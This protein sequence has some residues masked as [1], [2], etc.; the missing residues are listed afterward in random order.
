MI[1]RINAK[2]ETALREALG[3]V[4]RLQDE[5]QIE[6]ALAVLDDEERT[7]AIGLAIVI[8]GY[9]AVDV[10]GTRWLNQASFRQF[11]EDLATT[12]KIAERYQL[13]TE[14]VYQYLSRIVLGPDRLEDV[15]PGEPEFTNL[16]IIVAEQALVVYGP[17]GMK[18]WHYLDQIESALELASALDPAVL[19]AAVL[20]SY[21]LPP[22]ADDRG[23]TA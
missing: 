21:M 17:K 5:G 8:T 18:I 16:P 3:S 23:D 22:K 14:R 2:A 20:R 19:P 9:V 11:A 4:A 10:C 1:T 15:I 6:S 7:G 12:G 13:N